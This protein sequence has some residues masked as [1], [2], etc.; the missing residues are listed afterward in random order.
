MHDDTPL[1]LHTRVVCG[2]GGGPEKTILNSPRFLEPLGYRSL[3]AYMRPPEDPDFETI[4]LRANQCGA[5]LVEIDDRGPFDLSIV[6]R[7]IEL[8]RSRKVAVWHGHDYKSNLLGLWVRRRWPMRL[9][10]TVHGWVKFTWKT[11]LYYAVDRYCLRRYEAVLCVSGDL[12]ERCVASGTPR[13]R[14]TLIENAIDVSQYRRRRPA[15][16]AK[17]ALGFAPDRLLIGSVGRLSAEK[18]YHGLIAALAE[19]IRRGLP[20]DLA[21]VGDGDQRERL[22]TLIARK[23]LQEH[24]RLLGYRTDTVDLYEAMDAYVL[25]SFREGLPNVLLEA[26]AMELPVVATRIAGVPKLIED[27]SNGLVVEPGDDAAL[28]AAVERLASDAALRRRLA[29]AGRCTVE[30]RYSFSVR[31]EKVRAV[32]DRLLS[33]ASGERKPD[34][35]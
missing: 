34:G 32:Y 26:M 14:C 7:M 11:P 20:V 1:V 6:N 30:Q 18:N 28:A 21:I 19:P 31:M 22:E 9:V 16:E 27:G 13:E 3:C 5:S 17:R 25:S 33:D 2:S 4:R 15:E 35:R 8:C 29:A 12:I 10:T 23:G 24:V